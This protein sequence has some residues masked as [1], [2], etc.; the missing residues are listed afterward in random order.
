M[1][2]SHSTVNVPVYHESYSYNSSRSTTKRYGCICGIAAI[3]SQFCSLAL[4]FWLCLELR[5]GQSTS[6]LYLPFFFFY[7]V[8]PFTKVEKSNEPILTTS[9]VEHLNVLKCKG[10]KPELF[11]HNFHLSVHKQKPA[12]VMFEIK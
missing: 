9:N 12:T 2:V 5:G 4:E 7:I 1:I 6:T 10:F 3:M 8:S 11:T